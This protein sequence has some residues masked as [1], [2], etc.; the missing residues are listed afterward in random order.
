MAP[1]VRVAGGSVN[2][3]GGYG[4]YLTVSKPGTIALRGTPVGNNNAGGAASVTIS[5]PSGL[6][7]RDV[8]VAAVAVRGGTGTTITTPV[9]GASESWSLL[10]RDNSTTVLGQALFWKLATATDVTAGSI[11]VTI[12]S[13][14]ASTVCAA[15]AGASTSAP[16]SNHYRGQANASSLTIT[17][18]ASGTISAENGVDLCMTSSAYDGTVGTNAS[19]T[20]DAT[21]A[22]TGGG[23][24]SRTRSHVSH[25]YLTP[26]GTSIASFT[27]VWTGTAA[28]NIGQAV[29]ITQGPSPQAGDSMLMSATSRGGTAAKLMVNPFVDRVPSGATNYNPTRYL[30]V[31]SDGN[32]TWVAC[33]EGTTN[34]VAVSTDNG[35]TWTR[36]SSPAV[37][38]AGVVYG[39]GKWVAWQDS[40]G[41]IY[42]ATDPSG[43]WTVNS[44]KPWSATYLYGLA[45]SPTLDRWLI[46]SYQTLATATDPAGT[47]TLRDTTTVGASGGGCAWGNGYFVACW[48]YVGTYPQWSYSSDG[49]S[50]SSP[51]DLDDAYYNLESIAYGNGTWL[52]G[53]ATNGR[54]Y[55]ST[56]S[57]PT[58]F[59]TKQIWTTS[60]SCAPRGLV[61]GGGKWIAASAYNAAVAVS[62]DDGA[63]WTEQYITGWPE[64]GAALQDARYGN[65]VWCVVGNKT[66]DM[67][68]IATW[69]GTYAWTLLNRTDTTDLSQAVWWKAAT[70]TEPD[71]Y[72]ISINDYTAYAAAGSITA[73]SG[74]DAQIPNPTQ[75]AAQSNA[76]ST[77]VTAP[78]LSTWPATNGVDVGIFGIAYGTTFTPP[79]NYTEQVDA[80][81]AGTTTAATV[82]VATRVLSAQTTVG[83]IAATAANAAVSVGHHYYIAEAGYGTRERTFTL[84]ANIKGTVY[85]SFALDAQIEGFGWV[86]P[87]G[88]TAQIS[89]S[90][91]LSFWAPVR[92][93][94]PIKFQIQLDTVNTFNSANLVTYDVTQG[95]WEY[96]NGATWVTMPSTG[97]PQAYVG[98]KCR[99]TPPSLANGTWYRRI[100]YGKL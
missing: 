3:S 80:A 66:S 24:S 90:T 63:S 42:T 93:V 49:I 27:E 23:A 88:N 95:T 33:G 14:K 86:D 87:P 35:V 51:A 78:A 18:P 17:V 84:S 12:T 53:C 98:T 56:S 19:Y 83:S 61:Y 7:A 8:L 74:T 55:I 15:V 76:S 25:R 52:I 77:T 9:N 79:T 22:S 99:F 50:W 69:D 29:F 75:R 1:A 89:P 68:S 45:Y 30:G 21:S 44:S 85:R 82:E 40:T 48:N 73:I 31:A 10:K 11:N 65:G 100:R 2:T 20:N 94:G 13:N 34:R 60:S 91:A 92:L 4:L 96:W 71:K 57:P 62:T 28:V 32:G 39:N 6:Q 97:L 37:N 26:S 70:A 43:T 59:S 58:S 47:W 54:A 38:L 46:S 81:W 5:F 16:D 41:S 36:N 72:L 64:G 67:A